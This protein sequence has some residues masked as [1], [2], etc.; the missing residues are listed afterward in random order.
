[1]ANFR[2]K[3]TSCWIMQNDVEIIFSTYMYSHEFFI[4]IFLYKINIIV[5]DNE[6][7]NMGYRLA[8]ILR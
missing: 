2:K 8:C 7:T 3:K 1:M 6:I 4:I 5:E